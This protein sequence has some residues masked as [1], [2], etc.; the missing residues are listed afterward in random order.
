MTSADGR[1]MWERDMQMDYFPG[2]GESMCKG[3]EV[4]GVGMPR[5]C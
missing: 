3:P 5:P 1:E 2:R 4:G